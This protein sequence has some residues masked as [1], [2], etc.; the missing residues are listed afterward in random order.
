MSLPHAILGL[1]NYQA[2]TG[3]D[4]KHRWFDVSMRY[5]W[6]ADQ[7]QIYRTLDN[8]VGRGWATFRVEPGGD[9]PNRKVYSL[10]DA[11]RQELAQWLTT[12]L[13]LPA[14]RDPLMV[15]L[16]SAAEIPDAEIAGLLAENRAAHLARL[17]AYEEVR[18]QLEQRDPSKPRRLW[19]TVVGTGIAAE[20]SAIAWLDQVIADFQTAEP[21]AP[22]TDPPDQAG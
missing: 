6:P 8:L 20:T 11:G 10:T 1:L 5:F 14:V 19:L 13:R 4:L 12:P 16:F 21:A 18:A 15:Q 3:Y 22:A 17:A 7:A 9:R 2:M